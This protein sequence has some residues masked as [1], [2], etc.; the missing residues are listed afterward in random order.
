MV[1]E[2]VLVFMGGGDDGV[3]GRFEQ[4]FFLVWEGSSRDGDLFLRESFQNGSKRIHSGVITKLCGG[5]G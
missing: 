5:R 3:S 4:S 2:L 1:D